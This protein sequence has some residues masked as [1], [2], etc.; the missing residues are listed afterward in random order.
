MNGKSTSLGTFLFSNA[1]KCFSLKAQTSYLPAFFANFYASKRSFSDTTLIESLLD[2]PDENQKVNA[3]NLRYDEH[4]P[5]NATKPYQLRIFLVRH[6]ESL[7]NKDKSLIAKE[8]DHSISISDLGTQQA[9]IAGIALKRFFETNDDPKKPRHRRLWHSPYLR[10]RQTADMIMANAGEYIK[11]K[12]EHILLGEQQFGLFEGLPIEDLKL[13]YTPEY[14]H[15]M[16]C[17]QAEG[18]FWARPPLGESRFDVAKRVHQAFGS[19]HRDAVFHGIHDIIIVSHGVTL[20][21]FAMM[22]MH[23]SIEWLEHEPNPELCSI[24]LIDGNV[25]KGYIFEGFND[26]EV[27]MFRNTY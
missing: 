1:K 26:S 11:D 4:L 15:F 3:S 22:W 13:V 21:A 17:I 8:A 12:R 24:R 16:K 9:R 18:R 5:Y 14:H 6:G 7:G 20:R 25:D 2:T 27:N 10:A 23:Y 19:F